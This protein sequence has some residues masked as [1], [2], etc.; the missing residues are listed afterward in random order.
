MLMHTSSSNNQTILDSIGVPDSILSVPTLE[1][2]NLLHRLHSPGIPFQLFKCPSFPSLSYVLAVPPLCH[3]LSIAADSSW[4]RVVSFIHLQFISAIVSFVFAS[5][6]LSN[7]FFF[8][9]RD[10]PVL[11]R[12]SITLS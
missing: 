9:L 11:G 4:P 8:V 6:P 12:S 3:C 10:S 2:E 1:L 5:L 7:T